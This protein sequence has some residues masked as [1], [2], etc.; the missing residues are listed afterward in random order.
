MEEDLSHFRPSREVGRG[1][2]R[3]RQDFRGGMTDEQLSNIAHLVVHNIA[4]LGDHLRKWT[5]K[6]GKNPGEVDETIA[7]SFE[8]RVLL[9]LS[10]NDKHGYPP[11]DGGFSKRSPKL[12]ELERC[13]RLKPAKGSTGMT[14][15]V[16]LRDGP[17]RVPPEEGSAIVVISGSVVDAAGVRLGD[18]SDLSAAAIKAWE[19]LARRFGIAF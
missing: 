15:T 1:T 6:S 8:L 7:G 4:N 16:S 11:R 14:F 2:I 13:I 5:R 17:K 9:D 18:L 10:N 3:F 12:V 19:E